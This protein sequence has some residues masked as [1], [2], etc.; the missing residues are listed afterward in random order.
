[1][2]TAINTTAI[3]A[4]LRQWVINGS[5]FSAGNVIWTLG[6]R[7]PAGPY[8]HMRVNWGKPIGSDML[9]TS[10]TPSPTPGNDVTYTVIGSR[11]PTLTLTCF[12]DADDNS[13]DVSPES[14]LNSV[15][16]AAYLPSSSNVLRAARIGLMKFGDVTPV[17]V[18]INS[19][20]FEPRA[21]VLVTFNITAS[22]SET[23]PG[24]TSVQASGSI[25]DEEDGDTI[26]TVSISASV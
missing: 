4:A 1:M 9:F 23:G 11:R 10:A 14:V 26:A 3:K 18:T 16:T 8:V 17:D 20:E 22:L 21:F 2:T 5:G 25:L 19:V 24:F 12:S 6:K 7:R 13:G 15:L